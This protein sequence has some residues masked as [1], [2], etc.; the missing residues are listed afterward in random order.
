MSSALILMLIMSLDVASIQS[1]I[2]RKQKVEIQWVNFIL[3]VVL[4][5]V[6]FIFPLHIDSLFSL[7]S[8]VIAAILAGLNRIFMIYQT[9][10]YS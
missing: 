7:C 9:L 5:I 6:Q 4:I 1:G 3:T 10:K 2:T 8:Y